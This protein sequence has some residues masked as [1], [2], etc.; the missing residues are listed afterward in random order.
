MLKK[1]YKPI[2][3]HV[4]NYNV[5]NLDILSLYERKGNSIHKTKQVFYKELKDKNP[6]LE[7]Y[8]NK[9][10]MDYIINFNKFLATTTTEY[11]DGVMLPANMGLMMMC[12]FGLRTM[13][14]DMKS[15][16]KSGYVQYYK[17]GHSEGYGCGVYYSTVQPKGE[18]MTAVSMYTNSSYWSVKPGMFYRYAMQTAYVENWKKFYMV[19]QSRRFSDMEKSYKKELKKKQAVRQIK[20]TYDEFDMG[21]DNDQ[22]ED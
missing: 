11:K 1:Q 14:V 19:P 5:G 15:S 2:D 16:E 18:L 13:A 10:I 17:N 21:F 9:Q 6:N 12:T 22:E 4:P 8:T 7:K 3:H 20:S